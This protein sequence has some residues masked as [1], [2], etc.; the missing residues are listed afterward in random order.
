MTNL[1]RRA[2]T[3]SYMPFGATFNGIRDVLPADYFRTLTV[4]APLDNEAIHP[5]IWTRQSAERVLAPA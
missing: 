1:P 4:G 3:V 5:R 2:Y